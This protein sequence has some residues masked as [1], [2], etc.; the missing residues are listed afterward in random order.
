MK[1]K[2]FKGIS[3]HYLI[4]DNGK[5]VF[6]MILD[7]PICINFHSDVRVGVDGTPPPENIS[8]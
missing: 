5:H 3:Y 6:W 1:R 4:L 7:Y 2:I 8:R